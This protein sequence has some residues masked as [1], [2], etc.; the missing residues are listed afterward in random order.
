[1]QNEIVEE[2][3]NAKFMQNKIIDLIQWLTSCTPSKKKK[4]SRT[5]MGSKIKV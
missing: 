5:Y 2:P 3:N 1:M 4:S